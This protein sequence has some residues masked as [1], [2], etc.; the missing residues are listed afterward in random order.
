RVFLWH[1]GPLDADDEVVHTEQFGVTGDV[2]AALVRRAH[3]ESVTREVFER[4]REA[5]A[6]WHRLVEGPVGIRRVLGLEVGLRFLEGGA[7]TLGDAEL[8]EDRRV[9]RERPSSLGER[10]PIESHLPLQCREARMR[11]DEPGV[12][13]LRGALDGRIAAGRDPHGR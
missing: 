8:F 13:M 4:N 5:L 6:L 12:T 7:A 1:A 9:A 3:D 2:R 10:A 11:I